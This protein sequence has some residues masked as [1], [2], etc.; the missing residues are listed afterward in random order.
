MSVLE[1]PLVLVDVETTGMSF[2]RD[3]VIEV[4]AIR[5]ENKQ[6]V[7]S[8]ASLVDPQIELPQFVTGL[9]GIGRRDLIKAPTFYDIADELKRMMEGA[10][11]VAHNARFD[12]SFLKHEFKRINKGFSP[13]LL[14]TLKLSKA[15]YPDVSGHK[16]Q[17]LI[18]RCGIK[19][20][21]RHRAKDDAL[22]MWRFIQH[23]EHSFPA[24]Q[25]EQA[26]KQQF[27]SPSLPKNLSSEIIEYLPKQPGV[28]IF[29][30][31]A[32]KPLYIGMSG[33]LKKRVSSHFWADYH[34]EAEFKISQQVCHI[35]TIVTAGELE[36]QLLESRLIKDLQPLYNRKLRYRQE[37]TLARQ[38]L[39]EN[40]YMMLDLELRERIEL[41]SLGQIMGVYPTK[42]KARQIIWRMVKDMYLCPKL[43]GLE[44]VN[45]SCFSHQLNKC[46]GACC[47]KESSVDYNRRFL[48]A[49][50]G[51]ILEQWPYRSPILIEEKNDRDEV[52]GIIVDQWC[53]IADISQQPECEPQIRLQAK[54]FDI[55]T[56]KILRSYL[57]AKAHRLSI[58]PVPTEWVKNAGLN[59]V[60]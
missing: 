43:M 14:C 13:R 34:S 11:F 20:A 38:K 2:A 8:F 7:E 51:R 29:Q 27:K 4:A 22:V 42:N 1:S 32:R 9:T 36:A 49:F 41:E 52:H 55:D 28:Y 54:M 33:N 48:L 21:A 59:D 57:S 56:Y 37:L 58:R 47:G 19:D 39:S 25:I 16:L 5:V 3:R 12:L 15:L 23:I 31:A 18:D 50:K 6:I 44:K 45:G 35:E 17:D 30:D 40:G 46:L 10:V 24:P 26:L 60:V 53:V